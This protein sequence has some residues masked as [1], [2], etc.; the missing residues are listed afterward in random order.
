VRGGANSSA[1]VLTRGRRERDG[2]ALA[3]RLLV[4]NYCQRACWE[5]RLGDNVVLEPGADGASDGA[6]CTKLEGFSLSGFVFCF[7]T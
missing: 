2:A 3:L 7:L 1:H 5:L 4:Q 6:A